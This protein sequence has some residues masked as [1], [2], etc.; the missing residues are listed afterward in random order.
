MNRTEIEKSVIEITHKKFGE[1]YKFRK[2]QLE[3]VVDI[4]DTYFNT[5]ITTYICEAPTGSGKSHIAMICSAFFESINLRGYILTSEIALQDQYVKDFKRYKLNWGNIKGSDTYTCSVNSMPF[6]MGECRLQ[7]MS[8]EDAESLPCWSSCGYLV[9]RKKAIEAPV[10]LLNYSYALIQRNYVEEQQQKNGYGVPFPARD[11]VFCDEGHRLID[12]VQ[13]HFSPRINHEFV[14][15]IKNLENFQKRNKYGGEVLSSNIMSLLFLIEEETDKKILKTH[16][17]KLYSYLV[18]QRFKDRIVSE[19]AGKKFKEWQKMPPEWK[20]AL[21]QIDF[22]ADICCKIEDYLKILENGSVDK[23]VKTVIPVLKGTPEIIF[24]YVDEG[25]MVDRYFSKKFGFKVL[26][27]ATFGKADFFL[28]SIGGKNARYNR[29][30]NSFNYEK[31]PIYLLKNNRLSYNN[32]DAKAPYLAD[33]IGKIL[34]RHP[35]MSGIIHSGSYS[36]TE[37]VI[38]H[39]DKK[40][41]DRIIIYKGTGGK[42]NAISS[43]A[44]DTSN[45][46]VMGPSLLEGLDLKDDF[47]RL[48]IFLKVPYPSLASNF[49]KEKIK[50]YPSWYNWKTSVNI[51]QGIGR[52]IRNENDWAVTYFLDSCLEDIM[53]ETGVFPE[54]FLNRIIKV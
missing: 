32:V 49:V 14:T 12:I 13:D 20:S 39:L 3:A 45:K 24:N 10:S 4:I 23:M 26:M 46:I 37:K 42:I 29:L 9:N 33:L 7:K 19:D 51:L 28:N 30:K 21:K 25:S 6:T 17:Q 44:D 27:S 35:N 16:L 1:D 36:L 47:S 2:G 40:Y 8:Y 38:Y 31:S 15:A 5:D 54:E 48:Q 53:K 43:L 18:K 41:T 50:H 52:S 11:F 22:I 34:D